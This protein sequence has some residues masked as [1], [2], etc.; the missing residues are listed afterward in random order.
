MAFSLILQSAEYL[1]IRQSFSQEGIW[2][3]SILKN[4][5]SPNL[6]RPLSWVF[7]DSLFGV[8][9]WLRLLLA[10][11]AF[12]FPTFSLFAIL[13]F[14]TL[15]IGLHWRGVFNGGSDYM[16]VVVL[17]GLT[18]ATSPWAQNLP[19]LFQAGFWYI[20]VQLTLS[21]FFAGLSK[22]KDPDWRTGKALADILADSAR[23]NHF[24]SLKISSS[25][26]FSRLSSTLVLTFECLFPLV[27]WAPQFLSVFLVFGLLFHLANF[28]FFSLNRFFWAWL[29][30]Y[31]ALIYCTQLLIPS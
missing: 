10:L 25:L 24:L 11:G 21:Y 12:A 7:Q 29:S 6:R 15:L 26:S 9:L 2:R 23:K 20:S 16:T 1:K 14:S 4:D 27:F 3:F 8:L 28:Y 5:F 13:L 30:A 17:T 22:I 31:P 19:V 18:V